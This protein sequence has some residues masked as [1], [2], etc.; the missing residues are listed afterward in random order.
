MPKYSK[1]Q[2]NSYNRGRKWGFAVMRAATETS[3]GSVMG[4]DKAMHTCSNYARSGVKKGKKLSDV[5]RSGYQGVA[6]GIYDFVK[7]HSSGNYF[8]AERAKNAERK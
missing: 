1:E 6:D 3:I 7:K 8:K 4:V 2:K 5:E